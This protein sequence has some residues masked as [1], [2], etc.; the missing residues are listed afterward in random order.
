MN[1]GRLGREKGTNESVK[2]FLNKPKSKG[3]ISVTEGKDREGYCGE[4]WCI[5]ES[6]CEG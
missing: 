5:L 6:G 2:V 1:G 3:I 4:T